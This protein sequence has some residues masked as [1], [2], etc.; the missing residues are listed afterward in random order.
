MA[1]QRFIHP[2]IWT[3]PGLGKLTAYERLL[4]IGCFSNADDEGRLLG[5]AAYLR[6][7]I[8]PYDDL[9]ISQV[10]EMRRNITTA[11]KN[12]LYYIVDGIEYLAFLKWETYQKPKYPKPSKFPTPPDG[13][14]GE[15]LTEDSLK[16]SESLENPSLPRLGLDRVKDRVGSVCVLGDEKSDG[17]TDE[18]NLYAKWEQVIGGVCPPEMFRKLE[19][20][21]TDGMEREVIAWAIDQTLGADRPQRYVLSVLNDLMNCDPPILN[22]WAL[23]QRERQRKQRTGGKGQSLDD[24]LAG[25]TGVAT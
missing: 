4:F 5:S 25:I 18:I 24:I 21:L 10:A 23:R 19:S 13:N 2:D 7:T 1:R 6:S 9:T 15:S 3:D 16:T 14:I 11:C 20:Y 22:M 12:V 17:Q 8:F